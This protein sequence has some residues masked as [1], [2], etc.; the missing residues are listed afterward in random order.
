VPISMS[1]AKIFRVRYTKPVSVDLSVMSAQTAEEAANEFHFKHKKGFRMRTGEDVG[2][3]AIVEVQG[4]G[5]FIARCFYRGV[6]R[7]GG[8]RPVNMAS[9]V[10]DLAK[11]LGVPPDALSDVDNTWLHEESWED[12][13][14]R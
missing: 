14:K 13:A 3:Y 4:Y 7:K 1:E 10:D 12:A 5:E 9:S 6:G 2:T 11:R 8:I